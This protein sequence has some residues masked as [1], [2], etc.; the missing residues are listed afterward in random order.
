[1]L[2]TDLRYTTGWLRH[3]TAPS[4]ERWAQVNKTDR[5]GGWLNGYRDYTIK[6][7]EAPVPRPGNYDSFPRPLQHIVAENLQKQKRN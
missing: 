6:Q 1:V 4:K 7:A 5:T 3:F 2:Y